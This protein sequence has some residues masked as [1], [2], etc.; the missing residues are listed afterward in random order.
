[1]MLVSVPASFTKGS[2]FHDVPLIVTVCHETKFDF[3][4]GLKYL[5][6]WTYSSNIDLTVVCDFLTVLQKRKTTNVS[7]K[8]LYS[9]KITQFNVEITRKKQTNVKQEGSLFSLNY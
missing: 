1:M 6:Y 8:Q 7:E 9:F 5:I 4:T 3:Q 2:V